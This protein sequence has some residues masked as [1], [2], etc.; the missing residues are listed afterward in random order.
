MM[1]DGC[2]E[3]GLGEG[4][5]HPEKSPPI[6]TVVGHAYSFPDVRKELWRI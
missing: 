5:S 2:W 3:E 6:F 4:L 1:Q